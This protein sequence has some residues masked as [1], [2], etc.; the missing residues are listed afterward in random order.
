MRRTFLAV[1]S[2]ARRTEDRLRLAVAGVSKSP[3]FLCPICNYSGPFLPQYGRFPR[4]WARCP[5]CQ[6]AERHRLVCVAISR[7]GE[8]LGDVLHCAPEPA[9]GGFVGERSTSYTT[10]DLR[11]GYDLQVDLTDS[12]LPSET[13]DTIVA[14]HILE[15]IENDYA[16][17]KEAHR[18]LRPGGRVFMAVPI[19]ADMTVEYVTRNSRE[20]GHVRAPGPDYYAKFAGLFQSIIEIS[21]D[22]AP[23]VN[24]PFLY[25][26]R[27]CFP[28]R[29]APERPGQS[30]TK[31]GDI[32]ACFS[33]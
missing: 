4:R 27:T 23:A 5:N 2:M 17:M 25:E 1:R 12:G 14:V 7:V 9:L 19:V 21:S 10:A 11:P 16:A 18:L 20:Y 24:Q 6:A 28:N 22:Q 26:S 29:N 33:K 13:Y 30:G 8:S 15:H 3:T 31:H 32:I